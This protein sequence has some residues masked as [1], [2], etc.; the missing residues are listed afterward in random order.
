MKMT[1]P[2]LGLLALT[3]LGGVSTT[4]G[5]AGAHISIA[6]GHVA[7]ARTCA[8]RIGETPRSE[9][10]RLEQLE[11]D[12]A[13]AATASN[14][15]R[16]PWSEWLSPSAPAGADS[17]A[18]DTANGVVA[19]GSLAATAVLIEVIQVVGTGALVYAAKEFSGADDFAG[20]V[21]VLAH[22][23][24]DLGTPGY[25]LYAALM[26]F[27]QVVPIA[28]AFVM[29]LSAGVIFGSTVKAVALVSVASTTSSAIAFA[30]ARYVLRDKLIE[31]AADNKTVL[32]ID[33]ALGDADFGTS[34]LA[35]TL[36]RSS[37]LLP[38]T[39]ASY[40]FGAAGATRARG[41]WMHAL[42]PLSLCAAH[43]HHR[44]PARARAPALSPSRAALLAPA[45]RL[46]RPQASPRCR[47]PLTCSARGSGRC[48]RSSPTCRSAR[49]ARRPPSGAARRR[50][51]SILA[52][53][54]H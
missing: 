37:P 15:Y 20:A 16:M 52:S 31:F 30:V 23:V 3:S 24:Q 8:M 40:L 7:R 36:L 41:S 18:P 12:E 11:R 43:S 27:F 49:S 14:T 50:G 10:H 17:N 39:W 34:L 53:R 26:A 9:R 45:S 28:S 32:A 38:F 19:L 42:S 47:S 29:T 22:Y 2:V 5:A 33:K 51:S 6:R 4:R 21:P 54:R 25:A 13:A 48:P 44:S 1:P 46:V 35:I